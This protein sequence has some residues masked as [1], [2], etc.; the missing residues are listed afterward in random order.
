MLLKTFVLITVMSQAATHCEP[1]LN[2]ERPEHLNNMALFGFCLSRISSV[3][4]GSG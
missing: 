2:I 1:A 4:V 3:Y